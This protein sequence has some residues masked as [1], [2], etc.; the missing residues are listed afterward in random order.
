M[1][2]RPMMTDYEG[3]TATEIYRYQR[4]YL[5]PLQDHI[6]YYRSL[7]HQQVKTHICYLFS[8]RLPHQSN[9]EMTLIT[10]ITPY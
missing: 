1:E 6:N 4:V 10:Q 5:S 3:V 2:R 8:K 7:A 9:F